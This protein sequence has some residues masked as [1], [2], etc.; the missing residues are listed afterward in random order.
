M[1]ETLQRIGEPGGKNFAYLV[2]D[3]KGM[4]TTI[5]YASRMEY[6]ISVYRHEF[7]E[8]KEPYMIRQMADNE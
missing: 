7:G 3:H 5:V 8:K 2:F 1:M 6:A 4:A